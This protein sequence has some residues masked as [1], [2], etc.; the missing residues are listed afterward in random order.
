MNLAVY[1][2]R[3]SCNDV[4]NNVHCVIK[5]D[6]YPKKMHSCSKNIRGISIFVLKISV[7]YI[8][9]KKYHGYLLGYSRS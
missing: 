5:R 8:K 7:V 4:M 6:F 9:N 3:L 1:G 2:N